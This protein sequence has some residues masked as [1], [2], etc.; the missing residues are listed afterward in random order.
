MVVSPGR[1]IGTRR[2]APSRSVPARNRTVRCS[3]ATF[4]LAIDLP[5]R[6]IARLGLRNHVAKMLNVQRI[7]TELRP[8]QQVVV[9]RLHAG[10]RRTIRRATAR[11]RTAGIPPSSTSSSWF[12]GEQVRVTC[13]S[14]S[15][16]R[17]PAF[18]EQ[19]GAGMRPEADVD[20]PRVGVHRVMLTFRRRA[21]FLLRVAVEQVAVDG[22]D[23]TRVNCRSIF[24]DLKTAV[25]HGLSFED[26][27]AGRRHSHRRD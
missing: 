18:G 3:P 26:P 12:R 1:H 22:G 7:V 23:G 6:P 16:S 19:F 11:R 21:I 17:L 24:L 9:H 10:T 4:P 8:A 14:G 27:P 5:R 20:R 13:T 25:L 15:V 2:R